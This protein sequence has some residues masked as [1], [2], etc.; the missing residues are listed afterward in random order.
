MS[1]YVHDQYFLHVPF[2]AV[3]KLTAVAPGIIQVCSQF[4]TAGVE[5][6]FTAVYYL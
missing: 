3:Y 5:V 6:S 2:T 1:R 4:F